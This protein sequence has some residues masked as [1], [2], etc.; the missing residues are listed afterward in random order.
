VSG[1]RTVRLAPRGHSTCVCRCAH[2][3]KADQQGERGD[4]LLYPRSEVTGL[5]GTFEIT[6]DF[7]NDYPVSRRLHNHKRRGFARSR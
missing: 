5:S 1:R 4:E 6:R 7:V 2:T 3:S